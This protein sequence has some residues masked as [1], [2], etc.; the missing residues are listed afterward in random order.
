MYCA[1]R[2]LLA[3]LLSTAQG[4]ARRFECARLCQHPEVT[5]RFQ[6]LSVMVRHVEGAGKKLIH[7]ALA[8]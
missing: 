2:N 1:G 8:R 7:L 3:V 6:R 5:V 4:A